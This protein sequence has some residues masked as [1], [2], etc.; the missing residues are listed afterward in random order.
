MV[1]IIYG[2]FYEGTARFKDKSE[3][4]KIT[5]TRWGK[6]ITAFSIPRNWERLVAVKTTKD[7]EKLRCL[8]GV[9]FYNTLLVIFCHTTLGFVIG[10]VS[11]TKY[12]E[13]VSSKI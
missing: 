2:T 8:Q 6:I 7:T 12:V 4:Q 3:Y 9:R 5:S 10:P 13:T 11:N 1:L